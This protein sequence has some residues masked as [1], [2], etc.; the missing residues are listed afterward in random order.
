MAIRQLPGCY[1]VECDGCGMELDQ[2]GLIPHFESEADA[3][4]SA[5]DEH[6]FLVFEDGR[7]YCESCAPRAMEEED[8]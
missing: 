6:D 3:R 5:E 7:A 4:V 1:V 8:E 2:D